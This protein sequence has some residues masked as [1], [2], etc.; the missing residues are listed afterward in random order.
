M[1]IYSSLPSQGVPM[2]GIGAGKVEINGEVKLV[3]ISIA[4][5][6]SSPFKIM[7][8]FHVFFKPNETDGV[9]LQRRVGQSIKEFQ[10]DLVYEGEYPFT[11][12]SMK[13]KY[14]VNFEAFSPIIPRNIDDSSLPALGISIKVSGSSG[15]L[16]ISIQNIVG[17]RTEGRIN[18]GREGGIFMTNLK[19]NEHDPAMGNISIIAEKPDLVLAQ[20]NLRRKLS[21]V[22]YS[23]DK[24]LYENE[25]PWISI[26]SDQVPRDNPHEVTGESDEPAGIVFSK[27]KDGEEVRFVFSWYFSGKHVFYPYGHYYQNKFKDSWEVAKYFKEEFLRLRNET[28][29]WHGEIPSDIPWLKDAI[30]NSTYI[31][32]TSTWLDD[33]GRFSI[34]ESPQNCPYQGTIGTCY[35]LGSLPVLLMFPELEKSFLKLLA[36]KVREDGY[37]PHDL[38]FHS[39]DIPT[40]GTT[41]PPRWKDMNPSFILLVYRYFK[42]T[43]DKRFLEELFPVMEKVL[44][45]EISQD[46]DGDGLPELEGEMDNA[47]DAIAIK[48]VDSYTSSLFI[49][50]LLAFMR[51]CDILK[52]ECK[53]YAEI[54]KRARDSFSSLFNGKYFIPWRGDPKIDNAIFLGQFW[55][56]WWATLLGLDHIIDKEKMAS[57]LNWA[58]RVNASVSQ[59]CTPNLVKEN[60]EIVMLSPQTYSSWPRLLTAVAWIGKKYGIDFLPALKKEWDNLVNQGLV[61]NNPS[62]ISAITGKPEPVI[63]FLDHYVGSSAFWTFLF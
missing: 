55:G 44:E 32:S 6:W 63:D 43:G 59:Y 26:N 52:R 22:F 31:L 60:G 45:W 10:G 48:G 42:F 38:G 24:S 18:L 34:Y 28:L 27:V 61:W 37:V 4:N 36:S 41:S 51:A 5:N 3:N 13:G 17:T 8:G 14:L 46:K 23:K 15:I 19:T 54:L 58:L 7:R 2:G 47:F 50:S 25:E 1:V 12:I 40:D 21:E 49:A 30:I 11:R 20:Y 56:E 16:G 57:S 33:N 9:F 29:R 39:L 53:N 35:E 62:R